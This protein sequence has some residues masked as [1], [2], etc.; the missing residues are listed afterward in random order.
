MCC[1][2]VAGVELDRPAPVV[3]HT[4]NTETWI[5][6]GSY[7]FA[8][9][10]NCVSLQTPCAN[11]VAPSS[12]FEVQRQHMSRLNGSFRCQTWTDRF[13]TTGET[14]KVVKTDG[15]GQNYF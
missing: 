11:S 3:H 7:A 15:P 1:F 13:A 4:V 9:F 12:S 14:G 2:P 5:D 8:F 10:V 6:Y